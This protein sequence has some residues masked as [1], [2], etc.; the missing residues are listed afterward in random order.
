MCI[1]DRSQTEGAAVV[2]YENAEGSGSV[3]AEKLLMSVGRRPV[4]VYK[5]QLY[6]YPQYLF[7]V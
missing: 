5:R 2:S 4:D 1:R 7:I 3:V 6:D